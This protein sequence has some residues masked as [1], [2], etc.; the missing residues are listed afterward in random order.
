M[1]PRDDYRDG[2]SSPRSYS[3]GQWSPPP[4][5][6][7]HDEIHAAQEYSPHPHSPPQVSPPLHEYQEEFHQ[8]PQQ[9][10]QPPAGYQEGYGFSSSERRMIRSDWIGRSVFIWYNWLTF[11]SDTLRKKRR[12]MLQVRLLRKHQITQDHK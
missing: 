9:H 8:S 2:M 1:D 6:Q 3:D 7:E 4:R 11:K 12:H 5:F 10:P